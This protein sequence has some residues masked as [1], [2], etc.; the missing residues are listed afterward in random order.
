MRSMALSGVL[1]GRD[2]RVHIEL[3]AINDKSLYLMQVED[4]YELDLTD[5]ESMAVV[6]LV[7]QNLTDPAIKA[8]V[9]ALRRLGLILEVPDR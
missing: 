2:P 4:Y 9:K 8:C 6:S 5:E 3:F 7:G 1:D